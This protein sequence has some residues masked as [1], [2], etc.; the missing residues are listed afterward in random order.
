MIPDHA[1]LLIIKDAASSQIKLKF[2]QLAENKLPVFLATTATKCP[3][4]L[5]LPL[6]SP[7]N[8]NLTCN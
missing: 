8:K 6:K 2:N 5:E 4:E 1:K 3:E 7:V